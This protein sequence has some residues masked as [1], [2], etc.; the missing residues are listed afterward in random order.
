MNSDAFLLKT[1]L[2]SRLARFLEEEAKIHAQKTKLLYIEKRFEDVIPLSCGPMNF[3]YQVDRVDELADTTIMIVDY[4]AGSVNPMPKA[5]EKIA[6]LE[7]T[8]ENIRDTVKSFQIPLYFYYLDKQYS[9]R[10][11][12]AAFYSL[13][14]MSMDRFLTSKVKAGR[15]EINRVFLKALDFILCEILNP[16]VPFIDDEPPKNF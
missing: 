3:V 2:E 11:V 14:T 12:N 16:Q 1:V 13:R 15:D 6:S 5:V 9:D 7:L 8:R 10:P 4:K